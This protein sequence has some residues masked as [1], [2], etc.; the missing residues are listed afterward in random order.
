VSSAQPRYPVSLRVALSSG[1]GTFAGE[2]AD[3]SVGGMFVRSDRF[4]AVGAVIS[5]ELEIPD[6][7]RPA[8]LEAKVI[9]VA[10]SSMEARRSTSKGGFGAQ[11]TRI[12]EPA[13]DRMQRYIESIEHASK[14]PV[15]LLIVARDLL[16]ES[17]WTQLTE[18]DPR[19]SYCLTGALS[20][21][22]GED[23]QSYRKALLSLGP[24][25]GVPGCRF[26]GFACHCAALHW[27]D[28]EGRTRRHVVAKLDEVIELA[29]GK[30]AAS[31]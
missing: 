29:L 30:T 14:I 2:V 9:H 7:D 16:Y 22:A 6:G 19:G 17:G 1:E 8:P 23:R 31:A 13:R 21:A 24:R 26:G 18:R 4:P 28:A 12:E 3:I 25:L 20:Q 27:N 15:K 11:F 10:S 5:A